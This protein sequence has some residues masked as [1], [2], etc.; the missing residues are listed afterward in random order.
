MR[1]CALVACV[2]CRLNRL[3]V[4]AMTS[5]L[6]C[7]CVFPFMCLLTLCFLTFS[8]HQLRIFLVVLPVTYLKTVFFCLRWCLGVQVNK[9]LQTLNIARNDIGPKGAGALAQALT[10]LARSVASLFDLF[11]ERSRCFTPLRMF[12]YTFHLDFGAVLALIRWLSFTCCLT[13]FSCIFTCPATLSA[14]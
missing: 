10:V 14:H 5:S 11:G 4:L 13:L 3:L 12:S 8:L 6:V 2:S 7:G 9:T 1:H